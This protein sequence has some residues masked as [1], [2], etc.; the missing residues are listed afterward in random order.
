VARSNRWQAACSTA[1]ANPR[2]S[3]LGHHHRH[4]HRLDRQ[5]LLE[6]HPVDLTEHRAQALMPGD[7]ITDGRNQR[8][9]VQLAGK[10]HCQRM[11]YV[12]D[13]PSCLYKNHSRVCAND[14]GNN[15]ATATRLYP[16]R[17]RPRRH[18]LSGTH[19]DPAGQRGNGGR[20]EH[21]CDVGRRY[22]A[23]SVQT[24]AHVIEPIR[25]A[26]RRIPMEMFRKAIGR[27]G[28]REPTRPG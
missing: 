21:H 22:V 6:R 14:N 28:A 16:R 13:G 26:L 1:A 10:P 11:L 2:A 19:R 15:S 8:R 5:H 12:A 17:P 23:G 20:I 9:R 3:Q 27:L 4:R 24:F 18:R 7:H 25:L